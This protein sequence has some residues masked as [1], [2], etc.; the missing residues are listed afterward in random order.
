M[1]LRR[2]IG[3]E[4]SG[5]F[6]KARRNG[7]DGQDFV[8]LRNDI[9]DLLEEE[10]LFEEPRESNFSYEGKDPLAVLVKR[11]NYG[12]Q[13]AGKVVN[14]KFYSES[15]AREWGALNYKGTAF[16]IVNL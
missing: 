10:G 3:I 6:I 5:L 9:L 7:F 1:K 8:P 15:E 13:H 14:K 16:E 4:I 12:I 2:R 11:K